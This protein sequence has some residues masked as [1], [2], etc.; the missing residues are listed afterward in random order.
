VI[1][2]TQN[3]GKVKQGDVRGDEAAGIF[4]FNG[5]RPRYCLFEQQGR[6]AR[7]GVPRD[8]ARGSVGGRRG[9][10]TRFTRKARK[11]MFVKLNEIDWAAEIPL[12]VMSMTLTFHD[13]WPTGPG[14]QWRQLREYCR[15][16]GF[17]WVVWRR[18]WQKRGALHWHLIVG[19]VTSH[20]RALRVWREVT[21][22]MT[23]SQVHV[24]VVGS[25][26]RLLCYVAKH[27]GK[28]DGEETGRE[29]GPVPGEARLG[30]PLT[31]GAY[32]EK[33]F[34]IGR[35]WGIIGRKNIVW[36]EVSWMLLSVGAWLSK[37]KRVFR[38]LSGVSTGRGCG[39]MAFQEPGTWEKY[40]MWLVGCGEVEV[41]SCSKGVV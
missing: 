29:G 14:E 36:Y 5:G 28:V 25:L 12:G 7:V 20:S 10:V 8:P 17:R 21:G 22:D 15:R 39:F 19:G 32:S 41:L 26:R 4:A 6:V 27:H 31:I 9:K 40:I 18:E 23:I 34:S 1:S 37:A 30:S 16:M 13:S 24:A 38:R 35:L 11:N 33:S 2:V 3:Q